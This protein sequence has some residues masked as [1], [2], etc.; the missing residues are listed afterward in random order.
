MSLMIEDFCLQKT[1]GAGGRV[2]PI[3]NQMVEQTSSGWFDGA[4]LLEFL[5]EIIERHGSDFPKKDTGDIKVSF[6][7]MAD[8]N[9][10]KT[11]DVGDLIIL[12]VGDKNYGVCP[13]RRND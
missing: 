6:W 7:K 4:I 13:V 9:P 1:I 5:Q 8:D 12:Q 11:D 3:T 2:E 10:N